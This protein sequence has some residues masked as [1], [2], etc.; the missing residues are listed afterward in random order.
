MDKD[1]VQQSI[2]LLLEGLGVDLDNTQYRKTAERA[3]NAW[4]QELC[5]GLG[6]KKFSLTT[7]PIGN[8]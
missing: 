8:N 5:S 2:Q 4:V 1:K 3:A 6:E 7:F